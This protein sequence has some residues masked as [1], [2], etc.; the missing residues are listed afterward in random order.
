MTDVP[1]NTN[2]PKAKFP[3]GKIIL[4]VLKYSLLILCMCLMFGGGAAMGFIASLVKDQPLLSQ[5]ETQNKIFS[6]SQTSFA[7]FNRQNLIGPLRTEEDRRLV[8]IGDVSPDLIHAIIATED[9][10]F[11]EHPGVNVKGLSRAVMETLTGSPVQTGGSSLTQQLVK[12]TILTPEVSLERKAKEIFLA[13]RMER[14]FSKDQILQAYINKMYFGKNANG[15]NIYGVQAAAKGIFGVSAK[16][17]NIAQAAYI[18]GML[19][20]PSRYIPFNPEGLKAGKIRQQTVLDRMLENGFITADQYEE[21]KAYNIQEHLK[22]ADK[23]RA[24]NKYPYLMMEIENQ[25]AQILVEQELRTRKNVTPEEYQELLD[26]KRK[27]VLT[28]GYHI[29]TTIDQKIYEMMT[30]IAEDPKNFAPNQSYTVDG[31]KI[32]NAPEQIGATL[33]D[34]KTGAVLGFIGG[35]DFHL[36]QL[37]HTAAPRQPGSAMKPL[38]AYAPAFEMGLLQPGSVIEDSRIALENGPGNPPFYPSN[39]DNRFH[40]LMSARTALEKSYN[41]PAIKA[42]LQVGIPQALGFVKQMGIRTIVEPEDNARRNDYQSKTAVIGGLT[43]GVTVEEITNAYSVFANQ[44]V[45]LDSFM[46][47]KIT[48]SAKETIY[49]H[50]LSPKKVFSEQTAYLMNDMMRTVVKSGTATG[51]KNYIGNAD[52]AGKTGTTNYDYDSWFV[53]Y[54]PE[55]SLGVWIGYDIPHTLTKAK[56]ARPIQIWG[57]LMNQLYAIDSGKFPKDSK[58]TVPPGIV[59]VEICSKSGKLASN[60]CRKEGTAVKEIFNAKYVPTEVDRSKPI[61]PPAAA[62]KKKPEVEKKKEQK[63]QIKEQKKKKKEK[64]KKKK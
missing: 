10:Y 55:I 46:I 28:G 3:Y 24:Y 12:Q 2:K 47:Q 52:V 58:F 48:N 8:Q 9:R 59:T 50:T 57:K 4:A 31:R 49:E 6:N 29:Y 21:N 35:R 39:Y 64:E 1:L 5:E 34:N 44:G 61:V 37:N 45:F 40:G 36:S 23:V 17:L 42:Y 51:L 14:M 25:A 16:D 63:E 22:A 20:A 56:P 62:E 7:Y 33:L 18:A 11:Y 15:A 27:E 60:V 41:I 13:L 54:T 30:G 43:Q 32:E 19:Q 38:A 53:G 26:F